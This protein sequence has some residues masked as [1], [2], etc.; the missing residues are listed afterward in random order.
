MNKKEKYLEAD[1]KAD[2]RINTMIGTVVATSALPTQVNW[3]T[4]ASAMGAG[5]I[6]IGLCYEVK[7]N[8]DEAWHLIKQFFS[9]AG[10][11]FLGMAVGSRILSLI[12]ATTGVGYLG[13]VFLDA[14]VSSA[15]AYAIGACAK[16]YFKGVKNIDE[17]GKIFRERFRTAKKEKDLRN[18]TETS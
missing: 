16:A 9:A 6:S 4:T 17:L 1:R 5:V 15:I 2:Q 18:N 8:R 12:F 7:L 13:A 11:W 14:T 10:F 3:A